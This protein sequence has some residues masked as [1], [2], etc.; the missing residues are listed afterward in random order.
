MK[1]WFFTLLSLLVGIILSYFMYDSSWFLSI[2]SFVAR[3]FLSVIPLVSFGILSFFIASGVAALH[4]QSSLWKVTRTTVLWAV[5]SMLIIAGTIGFL[6]SLMPVIDLE[7]FLEA[8]GEFSGFLSAELSVEESL[9]SAFYEASSYYSSFGI[10][11]PILLASALLGYALTP[12]KDT[13]R[14]AYSVVNSFSEVMHRLSTMGATLATIGLAF[15]TGVSLRYLYTLSRWD[16]VMLLLVFILVSVLI[17]VLLIFP[18]LIVLFT[19][20]KAPF[21]LIGGLLSPLFS[22]LLSG[23]MVYAIPSTMQ[24]IRR[25]LGIAKRVNALSFP[26]LTVFARFGSGAMSCLLLFTL[27]SF[28]SSTAVLPST[29]VL[30]VILT[31]LLSIVC[32]PFSGFEVLFIAL[33]ATNI[34]DLHIEQPLLIATYLLTRPILQGVAA[35]IDLLVAALGAASCGY[36][37]DSRIVIRKAD[38]I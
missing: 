19:R 33:T 29:A 15:I 32:Y 9:L 21:R 7:P 4:L 34:L 30:I 25:N 28:T 31:A 35:F 26:M 10:I 17:L 3:G 22:A 20:E 27:M 13:I 12:D 14:P 38:R 6:A 8:N 36:R 5:V 11:L 16:S 18:I 1:K 2:G 23:T 24:H 37:V